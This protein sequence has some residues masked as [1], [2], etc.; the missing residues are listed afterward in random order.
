M[1]ENMETQSLFWRGAVFGGAHWMHVPSGDF[2]VVTQQTIS[3]F[4][5]TYFVPEYT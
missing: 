3:Y 4:S 2:S 5:L 1:C